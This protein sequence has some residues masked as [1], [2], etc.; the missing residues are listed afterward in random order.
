MLNTAHRGAPDFLT[1]A[2]YD[3]VLRF[4]ITAIFLSAGLSK[5]FILDGLM[6]YMESFRI[7]S[8][9]I[10]PAIVLELGGSLCIIFG[11]YTRLAAA[12]LAIHTV[13]LAFIFH[14]QPASPED[15][16]HFMKNLTIAAGLMLLVRD[17]SG[18][19]SIDARRQ[20]AS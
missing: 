18:A 6:A 11:I 8:D 9:L 20:L 17:G 13:A 16:I 14:M 12:A 15:M 3:L 7:V 19:W 2:C 1:K 10:Y 5:V 4:V